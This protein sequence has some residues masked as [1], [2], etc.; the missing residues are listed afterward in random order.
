[1]AGRLRS[2][3]T[4][5]ME[6]GSPGLQALWLDGQRDGLV[7]VPAS[8]QKDQ[9]ASM[10]LMLHGADGNAEGAVRIAQKWADTFS[11]IVLA[12]DSRNSTWDVIVNGYGPDITFI[13]Q[14]LA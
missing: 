14:A 10:L 13:D 12:V 8:Y 2:R 5:P 3:P 11:I 6:A 7:Y 9:Q 4:P 1:M